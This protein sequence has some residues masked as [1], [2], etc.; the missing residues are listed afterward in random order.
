MF[1]KSHQSWEAQVAGT[2]LEHS[3]FVHK[4]EDQ[5]QHDAVIRGS[6]EL[7]RAPGGPGAGPA[8]T[9]V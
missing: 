1:S 6:T 5:R 3:K 9:T 7:D 4:P 2:D 8:S